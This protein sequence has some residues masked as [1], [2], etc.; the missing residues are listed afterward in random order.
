MS[1]L[2]CFCFVCE[3]IRLTHKDKGEPPRAL[4]IFGPI[5][6]EV[7]E[8]F[9][10]HLEQFKV[11]LVLS[12]QHKAAR[13]RWEGIPNETSGGENMSKCQEHQ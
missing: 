12:V 6:V 10:R 9:G 2:L 3:R 4:I 13:S 5:L 7:F 8:K 1:S 11:V